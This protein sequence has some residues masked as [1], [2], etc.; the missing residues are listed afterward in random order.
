MPKEHQ[1]AQALVLVVVLGQ[2]ICHHTIIN[3]AVRAV[4]GTVVIGVLVAERPQARA[5]ITRPI[6]Q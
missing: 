3:P 4:A 2:I 5:V 6:R 1:V